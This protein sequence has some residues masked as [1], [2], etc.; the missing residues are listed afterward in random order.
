MAKLKWPLIVSGIIAAATCAAFL[1][2][3]RSQKQHTQIAAAKDAYDLATKVA[4]GQAQLEINALTERVEQL[5][6]Q[7]ASAPSVKHPESQV[8]WSNE[9]KYRL[10]EE[11]GRMYG[12]AQEIKAVLN[13][14]KEVERRGDDSD[15]AILAV[16]SSFVM[17]R[18]QHL[19]ANVDDLQL[20]VPAKT[21]ALEGLADGN[22]E[23]FPSDPQ[24]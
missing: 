14:M 19:D 24:R 2:H 21:G 5:T 8:A 22:S 12:A 9:R 1:Y 11:L 20:R 10:Y 15:A 4:E 6:R 3:A 17:Q 16:L 23:Q 7:L 18:L 13:V